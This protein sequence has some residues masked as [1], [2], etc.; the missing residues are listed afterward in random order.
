[1]TEVQTLITN[2]SHDDADARRLAALGL[3]AARN[4]VVAPVLLD[5]IRVEA[6]SCVREDLTWALVQHADEAAAELLDMLGSEVAADRRTAAHVLSK[7]GDPAHFEALAPLVGDADDDV[8]IK[9]YR[10]VANTGHEDAAGALATRLGDGDALQRDA[11]TAA[12]HRLGAAAVPALAAA[13][14]AE[15]ADVR[16]HAADALGHLGAPDADQAVDALAGAVRDA[17]ASVRLAAVAALG[18]LS[19]VADAALAEAAGSDDRVVA[20]VARRLLEAREPVA[21]GA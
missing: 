18:Q 11:L 10:A 5:R 19:D 3:G 20:Q 21:L 16:A 7:I 9:A 13:L 4:A 1:M 15:D 2:L 14:A 17:D 6:Q 12:M 8:A